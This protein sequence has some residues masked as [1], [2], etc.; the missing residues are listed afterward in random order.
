M[1]KILTTLVVC[2]LCALPAQAQVPMYGKFINTCVCDD[3]DDA[4]SIVDARVANGY[5][6]ERKRIIELL[7]ARKCWMAD[8]FISDSQRVREALLVYSKTDGNLVHNVYMV[9]N[10]KKVS[11]ALTD[12]KDVQV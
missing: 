6:S 9:V 7:I 8:V 3:L 5:A 12:T 1:N 11:Y 10:H 2:V 4:Q